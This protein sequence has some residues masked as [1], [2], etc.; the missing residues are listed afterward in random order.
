MV[1]WSPNGQLPLPLVGIGWCKLDQRANRPNALDTGETGSCS[2]WLLSLSFSAFL[3]KKAWRR[4]VSLSSDHDLPLLYPLHWSSSQSIQRCHLSNAGVVDR[5]FCNP[6]HILERFPSPDF[7][8]SIS[9]DRRIPTLMISHDPRLYADI[10]NEVHGDGGKAAAIIRSKLQSNSWMRAD[11]FFI[12][13]VGGLT[14]SI[15]RHC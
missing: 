11:Y 1:W 7:R 4:V 8:I 6:V 10:I 9:Y 14:C 12:I 13:H 5:D 15:C 3:H 2:R